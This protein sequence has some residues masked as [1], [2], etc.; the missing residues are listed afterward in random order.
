MDADIHFAIGDAARGI[1]GFRITYQQAIA[2]QAVA[3]ASGLPAPQ[4]LSFAEVAPVAM[5]LG[6]GELLRIWVLSTLAGLAVDDEHHARLRGT[7]LVFLQADGSCKTT[8][9]Q[10]TPHKG[11]VQYRIRKAEESLGRPVGGNRPPP[12]RFTTARLVRTDRS[13]CRL[14]G[15]PAGSP[16][17]SCVASRLSWAG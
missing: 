1:T 12:L 5:M 6:S 9:D 14:A 11:T 15:S 17:N 2:T 8:A 13:Y 10:L 16:A 7:L 3:L 4:A